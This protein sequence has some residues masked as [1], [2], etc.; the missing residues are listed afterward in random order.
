MKNLLVLGL[1]LL[2]SNVFSHGGDD[3]PSSL[4]DEF[5]KL[6]HFHL[7][8]SYSTVH[9]MTFGFHDIFHSDE[10]HHESTDHEPEEGHG[11]E[12]GFE[13]DIHPV[14]FGGLDKIR[15]LISLS[16][17]THNNFNV[18]RAEDNSPY[19]LLENK[20]WDLGLGIEADVHLPLP[21]VVAG[22]G[23]SYIKGK[24]YYSIRNLTHKYE[25]RSPL[26]LP[27]NSD[28]LKE[29]RVGD[30]ISYSSKGNIVFNAFVGI[31][32]LFHIGPE[33]IHTGT[34]RISMHLE[35]PDVLEVEVTTTSTDSVGVE[36]N[37]VFV[38]GEA[39]LG[40]GHAKSLRYEF[41]IHSSKSFPAIQSLFN[42]RLDLTNQEMLHSNGRI[43]LKSNSRNTSASYSGSFG[44]PVVY[45]AGGGKGT[46]FSH[47]KI[48][49]MDHDHDHGHGHS[50]ELFTTSIIKEKFTRGIL[51]KH[52]WE[53]QSIVSTVIRGEHSLI[54]TIFSW[55][56]SRDKLNQRSFSKKMSKLAGIF[57]LPELEHVSLPRGKDGYIKA[58]FHINLSGTDLLLILNKKEL[59]AVKELALQSL[60]NDFDS[61]GHRAFCRTKSYQKCIKGYRNLIHGKYRDITHK[62]DLL[63]KSYKKQDM[64]NVS[65]KLNGIS[66]SLFSSKYLTQAFSNIR[67]GMSMELRLEGEN[68]KKHV[69]SFN[70]VSY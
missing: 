36:G 28:A 20:K 2:S 51:S 4:E 49:E 47:G 62:I 33:Y 23:V 40:K 43:T 13:L 42:G 10:H 32:P 44:L 14:M 6:G 34:Y 35:S 63:E 9:G 48:E 16:E 26:K 60:Q 59:S 67:K 7:P 22:I 69:L 27:L 25:I 66:K 46:Y 58:D 54:S 8:V 19:I 70:E 64:K 15:R 12:I 65:A 29:W 5:S 57:H 38:G 3:G 45:L 56:F 18:E 50:S 41:N 30:R 11:D 55:S 1:F 53:Y 61:F 24:N 37:A 31:E 21:I 17:G 68:I 52:M 39:S